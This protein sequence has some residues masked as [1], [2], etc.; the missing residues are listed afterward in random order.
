[1]LAI[2]SKQYKVPCVGKRDANGKPLS[3]VVKSQ[4][5]AEIIGVGKPF[6]YTIFY[7]YSNRVGRYTF[8]YDGASVKPT[9]RTLRI[10]GLECA[11]RV[12]SRLCQNE[13]EIEDPGFDVIG[14]EWVYTTDRGVDEI[15]VE[16]S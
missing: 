5:G 9:A 4:D 2:S 8:T 10:L 14:E 15:T 16:T 7:E 6:N 12:V 11:S 3:W 13:R 1:M